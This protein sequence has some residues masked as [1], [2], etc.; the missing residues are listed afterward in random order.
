MSRANSCPGSPS[1]SPA[2]IPG[3]RLC[4][5]CW[6]PDSLG[7]SLEGARTAPY[8]SVK[9]KSWDRDES[10][11]CEREPDGP[12]PAPGK[13]PHGEHGDRAF[14]GSAGQE[15]RRTEDSDG[16][17]RKGTRTFLLTML[18]SQ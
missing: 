12:F 8:L 16:G 15:K 11:G 7:C 13:L 10:S 5:K 14:G 2:V 18:F 6:N 1:D 4:R 17:L 9:P 3:C